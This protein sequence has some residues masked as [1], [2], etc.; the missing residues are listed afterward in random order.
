M[1]RIHLADYRS[2]PFYDSRIVC[3]VCRC[4]MRMDR[5]V[6]MGVGSAERSITLHNATL[7]VCPEGC[8]TEIYENADLLVIA[9]AEHPT[10][11]SFTWHDGC[12]E[13]NCDMGHPA[14][15]WTVDP[16]IP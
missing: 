3:R 6:A 9:M 11:K 8:P 15:G 13:Q 14:R 7:Y 4:E 12:G 2:A 5:P 1:P 16:V 10:A